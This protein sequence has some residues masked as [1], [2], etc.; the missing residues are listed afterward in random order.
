MTVVITSADGGR[1]TGS[2]ID[3]PGT[4]SVGVVE[5]KDVA[6]SA[7]SNAGYL[8]T[9]NN[10]G[11]SALTFE[12]QQNTTVK[13]SCD[14]TLTAE[15]GGPYTATYVD[16]SVIGGGAFYTVTVTASATGGVP[17]YKYTWEGLTEQTVSTGYYV[18]A[19]RGDYEKDVTVEDASEVSDT[20]TAEIAAGTGARGSSAGEGFAF[21]VPFGGDLYLVW[22]EDSSVTA[23][24]GDTTVVD[25]SVNSP[26]VRVT[27]VGVGK[28][29]VILQTEAGELRLPVVVK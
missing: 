5:G 2:G 23:S 8:C 21:D 25:V 4:C 29:D 13:V 6:L 22:G 11:G 17:P 10:G 15:A 27:G 19:T 26:A 3:C 12:M 1:V 14:Y 16:L 24:S 18:F 9:F 28:A 7:S 20:D